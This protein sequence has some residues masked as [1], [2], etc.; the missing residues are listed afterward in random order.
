MQPFRIHLAIEPKGASVALDAKRGIFVIG[1][2]SLVI[3]PWSLV[4]GPLTND[5]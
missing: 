4:P 2:W 5:K 1:H 3:G